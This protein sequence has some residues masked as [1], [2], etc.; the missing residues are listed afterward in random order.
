MPFGKYKGDRLIDIKEKDP[1]YIN[2]LTDTDI[3][4][5]PEV[6]YIKI[7]YEDMDYNLVNSY[8]KVI[9]TSDIGI[10]NKENYI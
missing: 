4:L 3:K 5:K 9:H 8:D 7:D 2:W 10:F 1:S 6:N